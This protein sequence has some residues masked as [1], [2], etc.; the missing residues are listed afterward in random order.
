[1]IVAIC[2]KYISSCVYSKPAWLIVFYIGSNYVGDIFGAP[3]AIDRTV[4]IGKSAAATSSDSV[5]IGSSARAA[6]GKSVSIGAGNTAYGNGAVAIGDPSYA[7]GTG[8]FVGGADNI[9]NS[10]GTATAQLPAFAIVVS[11]T[12]PA[13]RAP[14]ISGTPP[15]SVMQV[16]RDLQ[17]AEPPPC[18]LLAI[19]GTRFELGEPPSA[20]ALDNLAEAVEWARCWLDLDQP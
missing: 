17:K 9:A 6:G 16:Y 20:A 18:T 3:L 7:S 15:T 8:A 10:D 1:M 13:N 5:A 19:S 14:L 2:N 4:A 11:N 12:A